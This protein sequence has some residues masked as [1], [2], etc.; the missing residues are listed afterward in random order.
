[1]AKN[2]TIIFLEHQRY[3]NTYNP[4]SGYKLLA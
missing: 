3:I 2:L 4:K 1:M